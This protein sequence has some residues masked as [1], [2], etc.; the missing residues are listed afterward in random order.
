[1]Y[2]S[3]L[4]SCFVLEYSLWKLQADLEEMQLKGLYYLLVYADYVNLLA[5]EAN[6]KNKTTE[7]LLIASKKFDIGVNA[8]KLN[9]CVFMPRENNGGQNHNVVQISGN[10]NNRSK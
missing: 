9:V 6:T 2:S 3:A 5:K 8:E 1:M 4:F 10:D 7:G